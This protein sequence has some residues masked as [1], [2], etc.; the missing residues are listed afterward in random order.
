[1]YLKTKKTRVNFFVMHA[2][3][4]HMTAIDKIY[5]VYGKRKCITEI[6]KGFHEDKKTYKAQG[7]FHPDLSVVNVRQ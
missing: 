6:L 2:G 4:S 3:Y 5:A 1:M 7:G